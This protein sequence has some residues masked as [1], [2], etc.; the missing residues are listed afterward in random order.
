MYVA[1]A[2]AGEIDQTF[3]ASL[4]ERFQFSY[5]GKSIYFVVKYFKN[6]GYEY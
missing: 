4:S 5:P 6:N 3:R 2:Q 1:P